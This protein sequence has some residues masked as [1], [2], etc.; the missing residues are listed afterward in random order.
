MAVPC[1]LLFLFFFSPPCALIHELVFGEHVALRQRSVGLG[2]PWT[3]LCPGD[4]SDH[5]AGR[6]LVKCCPFDEE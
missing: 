5:P 4:L 1:Q 6:C 3:D 2:F